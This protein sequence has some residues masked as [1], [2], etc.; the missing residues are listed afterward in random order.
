MPDTDLPS[1]PAAERNKGPILA[2]LRRRLP[3]QARV[4]EIA[5]GTGQ[6]AAHF[7]AA[8]AGWT[9]QPTEADAALLPVIAQRCQG[10]PNVRPALPLQL[11][12]DAPLPAADFDALYCANL[13]HIAPWPTCA[14]LMRCAQRQLGA[15][16]L[17]LVYG[18]FI[19]AGRPTAPSNLAFDADL[20]ERNP[21][22]GVRRLED[23]QAEAAAVGLALDERV[24]MPA[25]NL[26]LVFRRDG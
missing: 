4:L 21:A 1:S 5:S 23:V 16:G 19:V 18:P 14:A 11:A 3:A 24:E 22:W 12:L 26:L 20:R 17:L 8:Q 7:A 25:N 6:H 10:L 13:L 2:E 9:W 15:A